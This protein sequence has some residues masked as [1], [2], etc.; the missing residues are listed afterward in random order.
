LFNKAGNAKMAYL[1]QQAALAQKAKEQEAVFAAN[2]DAREELKMNRDAVWHHEENLQKLT[3]DAEK[4]KLASE[5]R[6]LSMEARADADRKH[7]ETLLAIAQMRHAQSQETKPMTPAQ[8]MKLDNQISKDFKETSQVVQ[9]M[10]EITKA[11]DTVKSSKGLSAR[12]GYTGY[13]PAWA[14]GKEAMTAE[15]RLN[16]LKGKI[17]Q[18]G[19]AM[20]SMSGAIGPMAVQEWKI[21]SDA[22]NAIDPKAGNLSE[23]LNNIDS[24]AKGA[25]ARIKDWYDRKYTE[26]Y[27]SY[28][29]FKIDQVS[30]NAN[31]LDSN[32]DDLAAKA[33]AEIERRKGMKK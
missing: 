21:V 22:V 30:D 20:A 13:L 2:K 1:Y 5:D 26:H 29:Q 8:K 25:A 12:E 14:Q 9:N 10:S 17:T 18:M 27:D 16:T 19:K 6:R 3:Q 11:I 28:P 4:Y 31:P 33:R 32:K 24:Q 23:Q 15:N 7:N